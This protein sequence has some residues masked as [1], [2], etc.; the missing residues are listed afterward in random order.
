MDLEPVCGVGGIRRRPL[1]GPFSRP[2][3]DPVLV[4]GTAFDPATRYEGAVIVDQLLPDS[5]LLTVQGWGHTSI[6]LSA[7]A[8]TVVSEYLLDRTTPPPGTTCIQDFGP[9]DTSTARAG[10][11]RAERQRA[12]AEA[13]E[14][15][16]NIPGR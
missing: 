9:F 10:S 5:A 6:F 7:C 1:L 2:T 8:H 4:V 16:A 11:G 12:R 15:I 13:L 14:H 3:A